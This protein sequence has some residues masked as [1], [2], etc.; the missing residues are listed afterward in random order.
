MR[1]YEG[2]FLFDATASREWAEVGK[3]I[4]RLMERIGG[5]LEVHVKFDE[6]K[7]EYEV[8]KRKR[9]LLVLA[10]FHAEPDKI[11]QL[12]NDIKLSEP[13]LRALILRPENVTEERIA[14]LKA[15]PAEEPLS[16]LAPEGRR[17]DDDGDRRDR[18]DRGDRGDRRPRRDDDDRRDEKKPEA[19]GAASGDAD[20]SE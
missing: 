1:R 13:V 3:E 7:L 16:P 8:D 2:M 11:V 18:R 9:G 4:E 5:K 12:E 14:E 15:H 17:G 19:V 10:Y 20:K 6:R